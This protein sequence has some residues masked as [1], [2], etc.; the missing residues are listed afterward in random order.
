M[1]DMPEDKA[2]STPGILKPGRDRTASL[3]DVNDEVKGIENLLR[4][5][6]TSNR[7]QRASS[8]TIKQTITQLSDRI[9]NSEF[10]ASDSTYGRSL[11]ELGS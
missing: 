2:A 11:S 9:N 10:N 1:F 4:K 8:Q 5:V 6:S 3:K 7:T